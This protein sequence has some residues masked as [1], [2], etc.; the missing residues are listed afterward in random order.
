MA[1]SLG[2]GSVSQAHVPIVPVDQSKHDS[3]GYQIGSCLWALS[4]PMAKMVVLPAASALTSRHPLPLQTEPLT[5][6]C[7]LACIFPRPFCSG[8]ASFVET[9]VLRLQGDI[10]CRRAV[11][12]QHNPL[13]RASGDLQ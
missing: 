5:T 9:R 6:M 13:A 2:V 8:L 4:S 1:A 3:A 7:A 12:R 11:S 10:G